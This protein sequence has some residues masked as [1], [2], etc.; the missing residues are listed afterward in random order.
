MKD[1]LLG[2]VFKNF[3][4]EKVE[5]LGDGCRYLIFLRCGYDVVWSDRYFGLRWDFCN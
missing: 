1:L 4:E 3:Y 5:G 2:F